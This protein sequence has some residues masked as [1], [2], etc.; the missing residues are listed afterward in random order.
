MVI[1]NRLQ[2][3]NS[4]NLTFNCAHEC[5]GKVLMKQFLKNEK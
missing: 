2:D 1:E 3:L 4:D 5:N